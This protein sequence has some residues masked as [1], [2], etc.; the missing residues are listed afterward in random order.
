M[1]EARDTVI[2]WIMADCRGDG[3]ELTFTSDLSR[4]WTV[5]QQG[6]LTLCSPLQNTQFTRGIWWCMF[7]PIYYRSQI[8]YIW[9]IL[10][11]MSHCFLF[12]MSLFFC[13]P[14]SQLFPF[15]AAWY[16]NQFAQ[17]GTLTLIFMSALL[18]QHKPFKWIC[19]YSYTT[20]SQQKQT[21]YSL[22]WILAPNLCIFSVC[23]IL[24]FKYYSVK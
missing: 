14:G 18:I 13:S 7:Y 17:A 9:N 11:S 5:S 4:R 2:F 23:W 1:A 21:W 8:L 22:W 15:M 16:E 19:I 12:W 3:L 20:V 6:S 24:Y 10:Q